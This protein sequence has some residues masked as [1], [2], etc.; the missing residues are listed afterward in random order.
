MITFPNAKIN[1]GLNVLR[2]RDNGFHEIES[3][4]LPVQLHDSLEIMPLDEGPP[5]LKVYNMDI[6]EGDNLCMKAFRLLEGM[7]NLP[8][9]EMH[10][11]KGIP[12]GAGLGGGSSDAAGTL[13]MLNDI[14]S[15]GLS[16]EKLEELAA[17]LGSDCAFF[18]RNKP[19]FA[20]GRGEILEEIELDLSGKYIMLLMPGFHIS[21]SEAYAL[22]K[23][24]SGR[25]SP[26]DIIALPIGNWKGRLVNDFEIPVFHKYPIL[27]SLKEELYVCGAVYASMTGSGSAMYGIFNSY[28]ETAPDPDSGFRHLLSSVHTSLFLGRL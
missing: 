9:V 7:F 24:L 15:L 22:V 4:F 28:P 23:P 26:K 5:E 12:M 25:Q 19:A 6:P 11:L 8:P 1:L 17:K 20:T 2:K 21:T 27:E 14:F 3:V 10:L 18:V 16:D 13:L